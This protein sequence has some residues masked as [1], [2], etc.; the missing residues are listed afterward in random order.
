MPLSAGPSALRCLHFIGTFGP[1]KRRTEKKILH[2]LLVMQVPQKK[3]RTESSRKQQGSRGQRW[4]SEPTEHPHM[5]PAPATALALEAAGAGSAG[6][7][8]EPLGETLIRKVKRTPYRKSTKSQVLQRELSRNKYNN[9]RDLG[10]KCPT[11]AGG[12]K[13]Q[14]LCVIA[15]S[16]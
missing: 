12:I 11:K 1:S 6:G 13:K 9:K 14:N 2:K 7:I 4:R 16:V 3:T 5:G 15:D 8:Q 10:Q